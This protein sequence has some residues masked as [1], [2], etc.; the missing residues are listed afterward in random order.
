MS[1]I[2]IIFI[3]I[4]LAMDASAVSICK[5]LAMKKINYFKAVVIGLYFGIF[6]ALMPLIGFFLGSKCERFITNI[7][8][9][10]AFI[11]LFIIGIN[12]IREALQKDEE[13]SNDS[14]SFKTMFPLAIATSI[15]AFAVGITFALLDANIFV[16]ALIIGIV[17]FVLSFIGVII[18]NAFGI[19]YKS[20]AEIFGG[21]VL[22][23]IG[24]KVL[25]EHLFFM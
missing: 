13:K 1:L 23:I 24:L 10:I 18:G 6:Q 5:G 16:S 3:G 14:V 7:D 19:K 17:T 8:H 12:M 25:I 22:I 9:W 11:L 4:S 21:I 15:D 2:V 20:K